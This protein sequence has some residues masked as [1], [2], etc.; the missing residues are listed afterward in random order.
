[1]KPEVREVIMSI[2]RRERIEPTE[3]ALAAFELAEKITRSGIIGEIYKT[4]I[5][6]YGEPEAQKLLGPEAKKL[7]GS[8]IR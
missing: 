6:K 3:E 5:G 7:L 1:M 4:M 2:L 8:Y